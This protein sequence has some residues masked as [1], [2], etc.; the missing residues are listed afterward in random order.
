MV[1]LLSENYLWD[2]LTHLEGFPC[3]HHIYQEF[4]TPSSCL[5]RLPFAVYI[6]V[7][8]MT[9]PL[10]PF[11]HTDQAIM[12]VHGVKKKD[13]GVHVQL[14]PC[15]FAS[16]SGQ[17]LVVLVKRA[18]LLISVLLSCNLIVS[19]WGHQVV[20]IPIVLLPFLKPQ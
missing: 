5:G 8:Q 19:L 17:L 15:M 1:T 6:T 16:D 7:D 4:R 2:V 9:M 20:T 11:V 3:L 14:P 10:L 12:V 13:H 18:S